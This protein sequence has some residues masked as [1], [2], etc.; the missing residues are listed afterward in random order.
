MRTLQK[1]SSERM[2]LLLSQPIHWRTA[3]EDAT[4][5][6]SEIKGAFRIDEAQVRG[7]VDQ[8]VRQRVEETLNG[9]L[10]AEA[11]SL[12]GA[13]R[14]ERTDARNHTRAGSSPRKLQ[15]Q[16]GEVTLKVPRLRSLP[17]QT[18][19]IERYKRRES[20]VEKA[21]IEVYLAAPGRVRRGECICRSV[22]WG[23]ARGSAPA[24]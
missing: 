2:V 24:R 22:S 13:S 17:F 20:L 4:R 9:L 16:A 21:L 8:L 6:S 15:T 18:Q 14:Y 3:M 10:E 1:Q 5:E 12:C 11:A 23:G 19:I 7:H